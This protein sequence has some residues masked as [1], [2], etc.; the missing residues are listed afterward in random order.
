MDRAISPVLMRDFLRSA[1]TFRAATDA[2][3]EEQLHEISGR[4]LTFAQLKLLNLVAF[5]GDHTISEVAAFLGVSAAAASKAVDRLVQ[6]NLLRRS[7]AESDRRATHLSLTELGCQLL[8][9]IEAAKFRA[10]ESVFGRLPPQE[11]RRM[12]GALNDLSAGLVKLTADPEDLCLRCGV[13]DPRQCLL[14]DLVGRACSYHRQRG[15][16]V[17]RPKKKADDRSTW[18]LHHRI[19]RSGQSAH[20]APLE[21]NAERMTPGENG[22]DPGDG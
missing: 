5:A 9:Q 20:D 13:Y 2:L 1:G 16:G 8:A 14:V 3:L 4:R 12:V 17:G 19:S 10:L 6:Q 22:D 11:L 21:E 18:K 7:Q 15:G